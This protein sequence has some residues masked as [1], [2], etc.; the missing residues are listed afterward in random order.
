MDTGSTMPEEV[1]HATGGPAHAPYIVRRLPARHTETRTERLRRQARAALTPRNRIGYLAAVAGTAVAS[2]FIGVAQS[3]VHAKNLSLIYLLVVLWLAT[4][5]GRGPA[6]AASVLAFLAYDFF[7]IPPIYKLTIADPTE[8]VSLLAL[9]AVALVLGQLTAAV[10]ARTREARTHQQRTAI[11]YAVAQ[12]IVATADEATLLEELAQ[13]VVAVFGSAGIR[14]CALILPDA[15]GQPET[16]ATAPSEGQLATALSLDSRERAA[17]AWYALEHREAA[18]RIISP[19]RHLPGEYLALYAPLI[20]NQ[21]VVGVLGIAGTPAIRH[22]VIH[23]IARESNPVMVAHEPSTCEPDDE[24][25]IA[26]CD[27][28]ALALEHLALQREAIHVAALRESDQLKNAL[29]GS[30]TH[31]LRTPLA[32]I[33]AAADSLLDPEVSWGDAERRVFAETIETSADRLSRLVSNLLDLSRLEAGVALP[34]KRWYPIGDVIT[35]VLDRLEATGGSRGR[36]I[37]LDVPEDLPLV[38]LDHAQLEQVVTNLLENAFK[39]SSPA[40]PIRIQAR[41]VGTPTALEVRVADQGVGIA[42][43]ELSAIFDKFYRVQHVD[44]PWATGRPPTGTGLGLAICAGII[45]AH[46]GRIWAESVPGNGATL[47]FTLP[48]P[49]APPGGALPE[50]RAED[51]SPGPSSNDRSRMTARG[52]GPEAEGVHPYAPTDGARGGEAPTL[53]TSMRQA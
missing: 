9:L 40:S 25:F 51:L 35:A 52:G 12:L 50:A 7:F 31:D 13:R 18:G 5:Y 24:L 14:A 49:P 36:A 47:I 38:P 32:A 11:L 29:L 22:L 26:V 43:G 10:Q 34:E 2:I 45:R 33:H 3:V 8:W 46:D 17:E 19:L 53:G 28:I 23:L 16:R 48:I 39:Y 6:I 42:A 44:L 1:R 20:A 41:V 15:R 4:W 37:E 30:V 27:Q 21:R